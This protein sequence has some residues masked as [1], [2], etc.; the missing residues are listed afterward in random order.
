MKALKIYIGDELFSAISEYASSRGLSKSAAGERLLEEAFLQREVLSEMRI[1]RAE[2][3]SIMRTT[4]ALYAL[5][6]R[7]LSVEDERQ[8]SAIVDQ[9]Y[10]RMLSRAREME[11]A[12]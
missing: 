2:M 8:M 12:L 10:E 5:N 7:G 3:L 11:A 4:A 1:L 9:V 6:R